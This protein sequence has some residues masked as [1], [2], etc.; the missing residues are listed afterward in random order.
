MKLFSVH[1]KEQQTNSL[2]AF[3][4]A[5]SAFESANTEGSVF[6]DFTEGLSCEIKRV[7]DDINNLSEDYDILVTDE[8]LS[9][10]ENAVGIP[11]DC[12]PGTGT[13]AERRSHVLLK[14]ANMNVQTA[15]DFE[16]LA[17]LLGFADVTVTPLQ[18][19]AF[20]PYDVPFIPASAPS[21]RYTIL[22]KGSNVVSNVPPYDVPFIPSSSNQN[23]LSCIFDKIKPANVKIIYV[24]L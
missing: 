7:Y 18:D 14:F 12:F 16:E 19:L 6:G 15:S 22:V 23:I 5:G 9:R 3:Y 13:K 20:P 4:P 21:S 24:N 8:L 17:V 2:A 10:W 11:D 1:T